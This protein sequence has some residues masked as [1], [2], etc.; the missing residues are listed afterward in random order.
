MASNQTKQIKSFIST[1]WPP[2]RIDSSPQISA[3]EARPHPLHEPAIPHQDPP[4]HVRSRDRHQQS[5]YAAQEGTGCCVQ[6][7]GESTGVC[8]SL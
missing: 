6:E 1:A 8:A 2:N 4:Q 7:Q 5:L 3:L